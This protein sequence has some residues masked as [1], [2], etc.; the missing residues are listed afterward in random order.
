MRIHLKMAVIAA[1][2]TCAFA[3]AAPAQDLGDKIRLMVESQRLSD[4]GDYGAAANLLRPAAERGDDVAQNRLGVLYAT[5]GKGLPR[6]DAQAVAWFRKAAD[7]GN[8]SS[9][10]HLADAYEKGTG[11]PRDRAAALGFYRKAAD[12]GDGESQLIVGQHYAKGDGLPQ[13]NVQAYRWATLAAAATYADDEA[14]RRAEATK[15]RA[16]LAARMTADQIYDANR[17]VREQNVRRH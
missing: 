9:L 2:A 17:M 5:G 15:F 10:R 4:S 3:A 1:V 7:K 6:D 13:D 16:E 12:K 11:V 8:A 14:E